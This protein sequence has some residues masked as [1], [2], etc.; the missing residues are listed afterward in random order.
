MIRRAREEVLGQVDFP[1]STRVHPLV[2]RAHRNHSESPSGLLLPVTMDASPKL[3]HVDLRPREILRVGSHHETIG[4]AEEMQE[5]VTHVGDDDVRA[6][7]IESYHAH[8][9]HQQ[10]ARV[11]VGLELFDGGRTL[12]GPHFPVQQDGVDAGLVQRL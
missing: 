2:E 5:Q 12:N 10:D 3:L 7:E 1:C 4:P 8:A 9:R 11:G 6:D